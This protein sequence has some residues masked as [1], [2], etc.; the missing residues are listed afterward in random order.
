LFKSGYGWLCNL[1]DSHRNGSFFICDAVPYAFIN[2][3]IDTPIVGNVVPY[4]FVNTSGDALIKS[5]FDR[6]INLSVN[7]LFGDRGRGDVCVDLRNGLWH[8]CC[9]YVG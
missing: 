5:V 3:A 8:G 6:S 1:P 2:I 4:A 9:K 7:D